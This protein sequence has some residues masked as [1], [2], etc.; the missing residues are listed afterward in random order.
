[1]VQTGLFTPLPALPQLP[2]SEV[3]AK[4]I[5]SIAVRYTRWKKPVRPEV[6]TICTIGLDYVGHYLEKDTKGDDSV[7][8]KQVNNTDTLKS[9]NVVYVS[10]SEQEYTR[11]ILKRIDG[12]PVLSIGD[13]DDFNFYGGI[14]GYHIKHRRIELSVNV[15]ALQRATEAGLILDREILN[16][17]E[18]YRE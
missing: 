13:L 10:A 6:V 4:W 2:E 3:K 9:C 15:D 17:S 12:K 16:N 14:I 7:H 11:E 18:V 8:V 5:Y 1:M